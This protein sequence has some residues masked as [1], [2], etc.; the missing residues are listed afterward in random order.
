MGWLTWCD[1]VNR[2]GVSVIRQ[3]NQV[4][5]FSRNCLRNWSQVTH[6]TLTF[7]LVKLKIY[8]VHVL[9]KTSQ[10]VKYESSVINSSQDNEQILRLHFKRSDP[11]D[12]D[13]WTQNQYQSAQSELIG[14]WA[15]PHHHS[16]VRRGAPY[17]IL[18]YFSHSDVTIC[19]LNAIYVLY[20][21]HDRR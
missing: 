1:F 7:D 6:V 4:L 19:V 9:T 15:T 17:W 10:R 3:Y 14:Q 11:C 5:M 21:L 16:D 8:R 18:D 2:N 13:I 20:T 12:L